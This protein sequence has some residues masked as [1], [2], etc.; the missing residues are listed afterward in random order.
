VARAGDWAW[1]L[2]VVARAG[3]QGAGGQ[4]WWLARAGGQG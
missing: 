3:G 2:G 1:W 4:G